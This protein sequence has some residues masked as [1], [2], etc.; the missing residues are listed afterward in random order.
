M[1]YIYVNNTALPACTSY[2]ILRSD[3]DQNSS[4]DELLKLHRYVVRQGLYKIV[5]KFRVTRAQLAQ[6]VSL[7][8]PSTFSVYFFD[9]TT[10]SY[11]TKTMY[12][13]DREAEAVNDG[14]ENSM[15]IDLTVNFIEV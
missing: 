9:I 5:T 1:A 7:I 4:R 3:M 2:R 13:G 8:S 6:I 11:V 10:N 14:N 12:A 15:L